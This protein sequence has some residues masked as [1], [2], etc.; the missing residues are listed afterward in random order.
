MV[1]DGLL[2][3]YFLPEKEPADRVYADH[4]LAGT[5]SPTWLYSQERPETEIP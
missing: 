5:S 1:T 4:G 2:L 3:A